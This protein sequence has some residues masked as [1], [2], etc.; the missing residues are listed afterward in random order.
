MKNIA[1]VVLGLMALVASSEP[2]FAEHKPGHHA[3]KRQVRQH[4][5]IAEGVHQGT[6]SKSEAKSLH[7]EQKDIHKKRLE[8]KSDG[9]VTHQEKQEIQ[10]MQNEASEDI[11]QDK[12]N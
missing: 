10:Q 6:I 2:A 5:R 9:V 4:E 12:H 7:Q 11:Y 3:Q 8:A 1:I